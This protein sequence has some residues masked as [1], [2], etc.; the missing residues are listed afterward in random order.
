M[1]IL[2]RCLSFIKCLCTCT[3]N[4]FFFY[5]FH[6]F[7]DILACQWYLN[8]LADHAKTVYFGNIVIR[9]LL[10]FQKSSFV[11]T[12]SFQIVFIKSDFFKDA[13]MKMK[14]RDFSIKRHFF[15]LKKTI[16][17]DMYQ[18]EKKVTRISIEMIW[19][20]SLVPPLCQRYKN[21]YN[22]IPKRKTCLSK[23]RGQVHGFIVDSWDTCSAIKQ[24]C[25]LKL[26]KNYLFYLIGMVASET[27][28]FYYSNF[29]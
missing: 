24:S 28:S 10:Y 18:F 8:H 22:Y 16:K 5:R 25:K 1:Q 17:F 26:A 21:I 19:T 3:P 27:A 4:S 7:V 6:G 14:T 23:S 20:V 2:Y 15:F 29:K 11:E 12:S 13:N 9:K